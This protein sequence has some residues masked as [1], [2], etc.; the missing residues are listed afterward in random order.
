MTFFFHL[1]KRIHYL[2]CLQI[3]IVCNILRDLVPFV[4]FLKNGKTLMEDLTFSKVASSY[5]A[6]LLEV[7]L[8]H[9]SFSC[10]LY[11]TNGTKSR[12]A[13]RISITL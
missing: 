11:C 7:P 4:Q 1:V 10:F 13:S 3:E 6:I 12:N 2:F 8:L 5:P 9:G